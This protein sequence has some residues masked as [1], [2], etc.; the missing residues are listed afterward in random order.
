M[1]MRNVRAADLNLLLVFEAIMA[2]RSV[3]R[4]GERIG[5]T[6]PS[7]SNALSRLRALFGDELFV[8]TP[9]G[10]VP[11]P[12]ALQASEHVKA[13]IFAAEEALSVNGAL[14]AP[15]NAEGTITLLTNDLIEFTILPAIVKA[16]AQEAPKLRL[17]TRPLLKEAFEHDLDAGLADFAIAAPA[18]VPKRFDF[19]DLFDEAFDGIARF[20]HPIL[21]AAITQ[22]TF[23]SFRH[24]TVC[25]RF[26][27]TGVIESAL[28][29]IDKKLDIAVS[30]SIL[31]SV[32]P[33]VSMTDFISVVPRRLAEIG[34]KEGLVAKF[35]LPL[36]VP[37]IQAK[38]I[39]GRGAARSPLSLW[40]RDL[41]EMV[42]R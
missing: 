9:E 17:R 40:F 6:Q 36:E 25:H 12:V 1:D 2:E 33:L 39:W 37:S 10:M 32:P 24:V 11:T 29:D 7:M 38:L 26:G 23:F 14:F 31:A 21:S 8:R 30:V 18:N 34:T 27:A 42:V 16:L 3:T 28:S 20:G 35:D 22:E 13:S 19:Y 5:L 15:Q 4:A 41:M